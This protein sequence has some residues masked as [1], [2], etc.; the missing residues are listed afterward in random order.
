MFV[1]ESG[2]KR[3]IVVSH[4]DVLGQVTVIDAAKPS[5]STA[6]VLEGFLLDGVV[7]R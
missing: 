7:E 5:R 3:K 6:T 1:F 4:D 2:T